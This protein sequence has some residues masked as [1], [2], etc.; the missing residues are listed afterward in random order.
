MATLARAPSPGAS[1]LTPRRLPY[2]WSWAAPTLLAAA[3]AAAYLLVEPRT[4]DLPAHIFRAELFDREGLTIWSNQW[5]GGHHT[6]AYSVLFPPLAWLLSPELVGALSAVA[7]AA[8]FERLVRAHFGDRALWGALWLAL[9][10]GSQLFTDRLPFL[11]GVAVGLGALLCLQRGRPGSGAALAA[12]S[13]LASPVAGLFVALAAAAYGLAGATRSLAGQSRALSGLRRRAAL[14]VAIAALIPPIALAIAFPEGGRH[15]FAFSSFLGVPLTAAAYLAFVR[16]AERALRI[17]AVLYAIAG[18]AAFAIDTPLGGNAA[19][20]GAL[21]GGPLLACAVAWLPR[22]TARTA[23]V[24]VVLLALAYWQWAPTVRAY[25]DAR[26]DPAVDSS[27]YDPLLDFL[28]SDPPGGRV[29]IPFT[30]SHFEA[31]EV[32]ARFPLARGWQRQ[33]DVDRNA[34]FYEGDLTHVEYEQ[35]LRDNAVQYVALADAPVDYSAVRERELVESGPDYLRPRW[36]GG[37]WRVFEVR[38][39]EPLATPLAGSDIRLAGFE[40]SGFTLDVRRP[41]D[42]RVRV[43]WTPYWRASGGCIE[44]D[45]DW[46]RVHAPRKGM[47]RV[48]VDFSP[49]RLVSRGRRCG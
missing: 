40:T 15:P 14:G 37:G 10:M 42:A 12:G 29:E 8:I 5:Y 7:A 35:W 48:G 2:R 3:I 30:R 4:S 33:L 21:F 23:A 13:A 46:T 11:L 32:G 6:P 9:A 47:L 20:L 18:T 16:R 41:G 44:P 38:R 43:R 1:P 39:P 31:A 27:Y 17:G 19:R 26:E 22:S 28:A 24:A 49:E 45:A 34:L 36:A 25:V